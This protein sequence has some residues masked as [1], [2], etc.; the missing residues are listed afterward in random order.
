[1]LSERT[2]MDLQALSRSHLKGV[3]STLGAQGCDLWVQGERLYVPGVKAAR[4]G[5]PTG[6]GDAFRAG[7]LHGLERG[8]S[9]ERAAQLGNRLGA[10]KIAELGPQHHALDESL[11]RDFLVG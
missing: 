11:R 9:L 7:L 6:C 4:I 3:I 5:D 8:W 10:L 1:M 2:G